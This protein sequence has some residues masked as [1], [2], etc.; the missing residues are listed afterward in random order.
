MPTKPKPLKKGDR[1][2]L[3][4]GREVIVESTAMN[5][6]IL[7]LRGTDQEGWFYCTRSREHVR[8]IPRRK[9]S[10]SKGKKR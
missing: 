6:L 1:A 9:P 8:A 3:S 5:G 10:K 2:R 4:D 7:N